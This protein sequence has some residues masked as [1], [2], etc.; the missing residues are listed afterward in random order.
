VTRRER[1]AVGDCQN[2][3]ADLYD[4][5][6]RGWV[7]AATDKTHRHRECVVRLVAQLTA[8]REKSAALRAALEPLW[9]GASQ[10][11]FVNARAVLDRYPEELKR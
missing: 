9:K 10:E 6:G 1:A 7:D 4:R 3:G 8:E 5:V 2:C 11:Y